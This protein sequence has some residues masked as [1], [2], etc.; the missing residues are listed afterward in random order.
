[1]L[2]FVKCAPESVRLL[3]LKELFMYFLQLPWVWFMLC[4]VWMKW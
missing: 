3:V 1:M 2:L 4:L